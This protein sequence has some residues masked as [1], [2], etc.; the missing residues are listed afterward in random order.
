M[1][2]FHIGLIKSIDDSSILSIHITFQF[3]IGLIKSRTL[4][5]SKQF[6]L[7]FNS[8]LV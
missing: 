3:H 8:T 2:Q 5:K 6:M 1:F 7:S 4:K